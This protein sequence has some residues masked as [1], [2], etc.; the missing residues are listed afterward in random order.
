MVR[1]ASAIG[2]VQGAPAFPARKRSQGLVDTLAEQWSNKRGLVRDRIRWHSPAD[3]TESRFAVAVTTLKSWQPP[4][5]PKDTDKH[6]KS[7]DCCK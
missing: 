4:T 3:A 5:S 7:H 2:V 6:N 1:P